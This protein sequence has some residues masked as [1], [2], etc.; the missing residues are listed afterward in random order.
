MY[1]IYFLFR[2][3]KLIIFLIFYFNDFDC[4]LN[5]FFIV[6]RNEYIN[7]IFE[8]I[9]NFNIFNKIIVLN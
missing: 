3:G 8:L 9:I 6:G 5:D 4:F 2:F 1:F 7:D